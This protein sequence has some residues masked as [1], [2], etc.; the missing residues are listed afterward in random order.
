MLIKTKAI[1]KIEYCRD[2][3]RQDYVHLKNDIIKPNLCA[4]PF[5][6]KYLNSV[7]F[8]YTHIVCTLHTFTIPL[9]TSRVLL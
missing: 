6:T 1:N 2:Y 9:S 5:P 3:G 4:R 7:Y 8:L